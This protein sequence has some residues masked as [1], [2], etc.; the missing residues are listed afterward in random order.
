MNNGKEVFISYKSEEFDKA[1]WVKTI[2]ETNEITCWMAPMDIKGG[3]NYALEIPKAIRECKIFVLILSEKAQTSKWVPKE[4]DQAINEEKTIMPFM[5]EDCLLK[6]D[7]NFYLT[8]V[9]RYEAYKNKSAAIERMIAEI[10]IILQKEKVVKK[11]D[12]S[13]TMEEVEHLKN[14]EKKHIEPIRKKKVD[15]KGVFK[16]NSSKK[17]H[18]V[19]RLFIGIVAIIAIIIIGNKIAMKLNEISIAGQTL[20]KDGKGLVLRD[21]DLSKEDIQNIEKMEQLNTICLENCTFSEELISVINTRNLKE[22]TLKNCGIT[23]AFLEKIAFSEMDNLTVLNLE[24]NSKL[25]DLSCIAPVTDGLYAIRI[26]NTSVKNLDFM[27]EAEKCYY[28][29]A[30]NNGIEDISILENCI[31]LKELNLDGNHLTSLEGLKN[32]K[33]LYKLSVNGNEL[34]DLKGLEAC[35]E[36]EWIYAGYNELT[37]L[38]GMENM[39]KLNVVYLNHN[40]LSDLSVLSKSVKTLSTVYVNHNQ[41]EELTALENSINLEYLA[42]DNN[43]VKSLACLISCVALKQLTVEHNQLTSLDGLQNCINLTY[44]DVSDNQ[45]NNT[46]ALEYVGSAAEYNLDFD[47]SNNQISN[48][49]LGKERSYYYLDLSGNSIQALDVL[50]ENAISNV[51]IDYQDLSNIETLQEFSNN[52]WI[53]NCPLDQQVAVKEMLSDAVIIFDDLSEMED[54]KQVVI[55]NIPV[56][57]EFGVNSGK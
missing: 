49:I 43:Q 40:Q 15:K 53:M 36:I 5:L 20:E 56:G 54:L 24:D 47:L 42:A 25:S 35:V 57:K 13:A 31:N 41:L 1:N 19:R 21:V 48:L 28:L 27:K 51:A 18:R 10:N 12:K 34:T 4:L 2:L 6:E 33:R 7:F 11:E 9:Q 38:T 16:K 52:L 3:S 45:L 26:S 29:D 39:T 37:S 14:S 32:C 46:E 55:K 50:M 8:N 44:I 23:N 30:A 17:K 22:L